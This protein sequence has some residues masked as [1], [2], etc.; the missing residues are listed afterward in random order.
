[1]EKSA[2]A[3]DATFGEEYLEMIKNGTLPESDKVFLEKLKHG[4]LKKLTK[5]QGKE[6]MELHSKRVDIEDIAKQTGVPLSQ[7]LFYVSRDE[8]ISDYAKGKN[9]PKLL[10]SCNLCYDVSRVTQK[11]IEMN[12]CECGSNDVTLLVWD[13]GKYVKKYRGF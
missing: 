7:L 9:P 1:M 4:P 8:S 2:R 10:T 13:K 3:R 5:K 12:N 11:H 6:I